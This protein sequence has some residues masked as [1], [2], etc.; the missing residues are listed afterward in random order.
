M[1]IQACLNEL[2]GVT[3]LNELS[4]DENAQCA[5]KFDNEHEVTFAAD[6]EDRALLLY[7]SLG[8]STDFLDLTA[9]KQLLGAGFLGSSTEGAAFGIN[10]QDGQLYLW[11]RFNEEFADF[12]EFEQGINR[13][14]AQLIFWKEKLSGGSREAAPAADSGS[15]AGS[16]PFGPL[17][18][19][20]V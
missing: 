16:M 9:L 18:G 5:L 2:G 14:L 15:F 19:L 17:G 8:V 10:P 11:K 7:A 12:A 3:G 20:S 1:D 6:A 13:F 4:L